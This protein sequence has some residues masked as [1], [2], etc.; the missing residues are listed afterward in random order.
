MRRLLVINVSLILTAFVLIGCNKSDRE[1][2]NTGPSTPNITVA[3]NS[4]LSNAN[5]MNANL[6]AT[7]SANMN[8]SNMNMNP[9]DNP[10]DVKGFMTTAAESGMAEVQLGQLAQQKA[11]N[12][13]VKQFAQRMVTDHTKANNELKQLAQK[14]NVTLPTDLN[15]KHKELM[16]RL[17]GLS[18]AEFDREYMKAQVDDHEKA[19]SLFQSQA[20]KGDNAQAKAFASKTLPTLKQHLEMAR[21]IN[22]KLK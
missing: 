13:D 5:S 8:S 17:Q 7:N 11:Q 6:S 1:N 22:G 3:G 15:A 20:D 10:T 19:V 16:S 12:A 9:M 21:D 18:G 14:E 4:S 2:I